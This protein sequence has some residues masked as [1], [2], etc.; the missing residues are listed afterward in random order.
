MTANTK[1]ENKIQ[2]I[3]FD[4]IKKKLGGVTSITCQEFLYAIN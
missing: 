4:L 3:K 1:I 2:I